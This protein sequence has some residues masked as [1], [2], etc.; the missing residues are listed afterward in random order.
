MAWVLQDGARPA[1]VRAPRA[2]T[3]SAAHCH[4]LRDL[5]RL[6]FSESS[7]FRA[8]LELPPAWACSVSPL[9]EGALRELSL[10]RC[11][12]EGADD[13]S[14]AWKAVRWGPCEGPSLVPV[15]YCS[16]E[17][18]CRSC[19]DGTAVQGQEAKVAIKMQ[20]AEGPECRP[21]QPSPQPGPVSQVT[22]VGGTFP[23]KT[24]EPLP[25]PSGE[26]H[27]LTLFLSCFFS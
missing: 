19:N 8:S 12:W 18:E 21:A 22:L 23:R 15:P 5:G 1:S 10:H 9:G 4:G 17:K 27:E 26:S 2:V 25:F 20:R 3:A 14:Q 7:H 6:A 16:A 24:F 11:P 13:E